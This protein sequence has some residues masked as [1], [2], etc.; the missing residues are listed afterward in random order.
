MTWEI[1]QED[2][3]LPFKLLKHEQLNEKHKKIKTL[4]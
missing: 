3:T 4:T 2:S 1:R